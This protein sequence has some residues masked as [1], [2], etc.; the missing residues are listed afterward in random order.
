MEE[1]L[2]HQLKNIDGKIVLKDI[3]KFN[4]TVMEAL[5]I[6]LSTNI[7]I[8]ITFHISCMIDRL[9]DKVIIDEFEGKK[10]YIKDNFNLYRIIKNACASLNEKKIVLKSINVFYFSKP[11]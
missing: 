5:N 1:T 4:S 2:E 9:K 11:F 3:K 6:T 7:L 8:G 10:E